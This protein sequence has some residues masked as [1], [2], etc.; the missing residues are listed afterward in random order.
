MPSWAGS[1]SAF[2]EFL[3]I[4]QGKECS[5]NIIFKFW[6][7]A[8]I[9]KL[10]NHPRE[11]LN[12][13]LLAFEWECWIKR[14]QRFLSRYNIMWFSD[15]VAESGREIKFRWKE[16]WN[17]IYP[18]LITVWWIIKW[19]RKMI[20]VDETLKLEYNMGEYAKIYLMWLENLI[21]GKL[22]LNSS[23]VM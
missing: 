5:L 6:H 2:L 20:L 21:I 16:L 11:K 9:V 22:F 14:Y 17:Q 4:T 18:T 12:A 7:Q 19:L 8:N 13:S 23:F 3:K 10:I 15:M 1:M